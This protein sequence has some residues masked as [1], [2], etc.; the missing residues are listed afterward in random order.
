MRLDNIFKMLE[1][2]DFYRESKNIDIAK[3]INEFTLNPKK[4]YKQ[5]IRAWRSK[6]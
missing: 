3:G 1:I 5:K 2:D 6:R 4:L